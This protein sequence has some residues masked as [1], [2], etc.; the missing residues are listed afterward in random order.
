MYTQAISVTH[1]RQCTSPLTLNSYLQAA[2]HLR[3]ESHSASACY[4]PPFHYSKACRSSWSRHSSNC[5]CN[6]TKRM[7][8]SN[9]LAMHSAFFA[10]HEVGVL[11]FNPRPLLTPVMNPSHRCLMNSQAIHAC[12]QQYT[13]RSAFTRVC[14]CYNSLYR[15]AVAAADGRGSR[16]AGVVRDASRDFTLSHRRLSR[17]GTGQ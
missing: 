5:S 12:Q 7:Q 2:S 3:C 13:A 4:V 1:A 15:C 6:S 8:R 11:I 16:F 10:V 14:R 17:C 9:W